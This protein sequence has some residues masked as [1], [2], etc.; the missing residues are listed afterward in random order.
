MFAKAFFA[1]YLPVLAA[2]SIVPVFL[3]NE[4]M[5]QFLVLAAVVLFL[6]IRPQGLFTTKER[7]Y[8]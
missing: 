8:E 2:M 1:K 6:I 5:A 3:G 4:M 7:S